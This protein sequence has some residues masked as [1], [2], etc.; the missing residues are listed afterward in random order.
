[1]VAQGNTTRLVPLAFTGTFSPGNPNPAPASGT[2][3]IRYASSNPTVA[4]VTDSGVVRGV[5]AGSAVVTVAAGGKSLQVPVTVVRPYTLTFLGTLG[6][7]GSQAAAINQSGQVVGQA[8]LADGAW[9]AFLWESG[10]MRDLGSLGYPYSEAVAINDQGVVVGN[11]GERSCVDCGPSGPG[12]KQPWRWASGAMMPISAGQ[13]SG[14]AAILTDINNQGQ[15]AGYTFSGY[16]RFATGEGFAWKDGVVTWIGKAGRGYDGG[17]VY[18]SAAMAINDEGAVAA[19]MTYYAS[20]TQAY[21]WRNGQLTPARPQGVTYT[22]AGDINQ[23]GQVAGGYYNASVWFRVGVFTWENGTAHAPELTLGLSGYMGIGKG[24]NNHGHV[25]GSAP[26]EGGSYGFLWRD[27]VTV[28]LNE[29]AVAAEWE[30]YGAT[31]IND[32]GQIV[33]YGRHRTSGATGALLLTPA[34]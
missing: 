11:A 3:T 27:G 6:G 24:I 1:M 17:Q 16:S 34:P 19:T 9:R 13:P 7:K 18:R 23:K 29:L 28:N 30:V 15:I 10:Q 5:S 12:L 33:G 2:H 20:D 8:Q 32:H 4:T 31:G 22:A 14:E 21:V 25:V 26:R